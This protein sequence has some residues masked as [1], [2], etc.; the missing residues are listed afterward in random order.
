MKDKEILLKRC[1]KCKEFKNLEF[2]SQ[3][4]K[5]KDRKR[6]QCKECDRKY[7]QKNKEKIAQ[8]YPEHKEK[9]TQRMRE[10]Y[11]ENKKEYAQYYQKHKKEIAQRK[12]KWEKKNKEY[13]RK[14]NREYQQTHKEEKNQH[15]RTRYITD[16]N[17]KLNY[18][19]SNAIGRVKNHS[20]KQGQSWKYLLPY[21]L[22]QLK[23]HLKSTL[24]KGYTW[25]NFVQGKLHI[26][27]ILPISI[28]EYEK[29]EDLDFQVCWGLDNL[30]L[31]PVKENLMKHAKLVVPFQKTF[32]IEVK[33]RNKCLS[34]T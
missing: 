23:K 2:F 25:K 14:H 34:Q 32:A 13:R 3:D 11:Q 22:V 33:L 6:S 19:M 26:D 24:P 7:C 8:Y 4:K 5:T 20:I 15:Q 18:L 9:L 16:P 1:S 10:Y 29:A 12:R 21:T 28:F 17:Y 31:L 30:R 27:H